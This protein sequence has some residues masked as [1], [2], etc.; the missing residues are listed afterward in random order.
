MHPDK[1]IER[2]I[3]LARHVSTWSKDPSTQVGAV[4]AD[5]KKRI[6]SLGFNGLPRRVEDS[7]SVLYNRETKLKLTLHAEENAL[8]FARSSV[9]GCTL[10]ATHPPCAKCAAMIVQASIASVIV[11][12]PDEIFISR[13]QTD[14]ALAQKVFSEAGVN[15]KFF[16]QGK[17]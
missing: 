8:L 3:G 16:G 6:V 12:L 11:P 13:W 4:I 14:V 1:W 10:Y 17:L 9:E 15:F 5:D 2:F 7:A